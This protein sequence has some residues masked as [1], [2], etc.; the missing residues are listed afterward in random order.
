MRG[1]PWIR[2][3]PRPEASNA[4]SSRQVVPDSCTSQDTGSTPGPAP[5]R[6]PPTPRT[7]YAP[8]P[9]G[10]NTAPAALNTARVRS[11]S[12]LSNTPSTT[13][14][15]PA[16]AAP[17][18]TL[19]DTDLDGGASTRTGSITY[20]SRGRASLQ[21]RYARCSAGQMKNNQVITAKSGQRMPTDHTI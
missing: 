20:S 5:V 15:P 8:G 10:S 4:V 13:D 17:I 19:C 2:K 18:N 21:T 12:L 14:S 16:R 7:R 11:G 6:A 3:R 9:K 1:A